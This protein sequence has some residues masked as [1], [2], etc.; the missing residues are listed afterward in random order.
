MFAEESSMAM[1]LSLMA[2]SGVVRKQPKT[3][4]QLQLS[5]RMYW[6]CLGF[7]HPNDTTIAFRL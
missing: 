3:P 7:I 4:S 6:L 5:D 1:R 2:V